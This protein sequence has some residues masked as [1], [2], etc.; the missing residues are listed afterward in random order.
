MQLLS[1]VLEL[2]LD[3]SLHVCIHEQQR[4]LLLLHNGCLLSKGFVGVW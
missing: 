1:Q 2:V 4:L 3:V